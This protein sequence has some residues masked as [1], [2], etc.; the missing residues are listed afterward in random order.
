MCYARGP[1]C[2]THSKER[3]DKAHEALK[4]KPTEN[5]IK[6]FKDAVLQ[7]DTTPQGVQ[8]L[9]EKVS[10]E[11]NPEDKEHYKKGSLWRRR[12]PKPNERTNPRPKAKRN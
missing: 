11:D 5:N 10:N 3:Y 4:E 6:R 9:A 8:K 2:Y 1:Y 7:L 12:Q